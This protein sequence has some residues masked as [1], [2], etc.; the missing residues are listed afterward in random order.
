MPV[1]SEIIF[2]S[3]RGPGGGAVGA[4]ISEFKNVHALLPASERKRFT[5]QIKKRTEPLKVAPAGFIMREKP[6]G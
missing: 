6:E 5:I 2:G 1:L 3:Y 4:Q